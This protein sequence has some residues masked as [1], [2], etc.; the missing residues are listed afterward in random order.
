MA[1]TSAGMCSAQF[2]GLRVSN[3][4]LYIPAHEKN[5]QT[6]SAQ[7][8]LRAY[9]NH[10]KGKR[11]DV[12]DFT[13]WGKLADVC[14]KSCMPGKEFH[15]EVEPESYNG[16]VY[17][18]EGKRL[19][20]NSNGTE[21]LVRRVGFRITKIRFG[22]ESKKQIDME[23]QKAIRPADWNDGGKGSEAWSAMLK[24]I[25]AKTYDGGD[26]FGY[27]K[28]YKVGGNAVAANSGPAEAAKTVYGA[29]A[30]NI[31]KVASGA[32]NPFVTG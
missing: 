18:D 31:A 15:A 32:V 12:F 27:A 25:H 29:M 11:S 20:T 16:K 28:V 22:A 5:G 13:A 6:I 3:T 9:V 7:C 24:T 30:E 4:P 8:K 26:T 17:A 19:V 23:I 21:C 14:A 2:T 1:G 10:P